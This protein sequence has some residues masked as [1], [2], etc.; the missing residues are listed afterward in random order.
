MKRG[1][2]T[3]AR[4]SLTRSHPRHKDSLRRSAA[5]DAVDAA[6]HAIDGKKSGKGTSPHLVSLVVSA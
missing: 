4:A 3:P 1:R 5:V 6:A 2:T